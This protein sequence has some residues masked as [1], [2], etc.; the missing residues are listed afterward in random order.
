MFVVILIYNKIAWALY[1]ALGSKYGKKTADVI[2]V[3][4][5]F[6]FASWLVFNQFYF[7]AV[8]GFIL[9]IETNLNTEFQKT[10]KRMFKNKSK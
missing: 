6:L 1:F 7:F 8:V 5:S 10:L 3:V 4:H 2:D 9:W